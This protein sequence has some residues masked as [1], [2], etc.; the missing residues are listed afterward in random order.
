MERKSE[1]YNYVSYNTAE[2]LACSFIQY[3][4]P[5]LTIQEDQ[6]EVKHSPSFATVSNK[7]LLDEADMYHILKTAT[8]KV[9]DE[10]S[11]ETCDTT[12]NLEEQMITLLEQISKEDIA[13]HKSLYE[14]NQDDARREVQYILEKNDLELVWFD[15]RS[16]SD[17]DEY[18]LALEVL[19][20]ENVTTFLIDN[21]ITKADAAV[22]TFIKEE[23]K[24]VA[25][26]K[27]EGSA[28]VVILSGDKKNKKYAIKD[29]YIVSEHFVDVECAS[30]SSLTNIESIDSHEASHTEHS[31]EDEY[32]SDYQFTATAQ[33]LPSVEYC[34][35]NIV[36]DYEIE[37]FFLPYKIPDTKIHANKSIS[38]FGATIWT[39]E[40]NLES[41]ELF[42][43]GIGIEIQSASYNV[44]STF[45]EQFPFAYTIRDSKR[46]VNKNKSLIGATV[47]TVEETFETTNLISSEGYY[48]FSLDTGTEI[49]HNTRS[50]QNRIVEEQFC[51]PY[52]ILHSATCTSK[53]RSLFG[54][55]TETG[56]GT[57]ES[58]DLITS[59]EYCCFTTDTGTEIEGVS[60]GELGIFTEEHY[61]ILSDDAKIRT[62]I[63]E[64]CHLLRELESHLVCQLL[65]HEV[66]SLSL[67]YED[68]NA[69]SRPAYCSIPVHFVSEEVLCMEKTEEVYFMAEY[70]EGSNCCTTIDDRTVTGICT[71]YREHKPEVAHQ[72]ENSTFGRA[73]RHTVGP[74]RE[75]EMRISKSFDVEKVCADINSNSRWTDS[76]DEI[77]AKRIINFSAKDAP[78]LLFGAEQLEPQGI[79]V[80]RHP[81]TENSATQTS[82]HTNLEEKSQN[83]N[84]IG[85]SNKH[86]QTSRSVIGQRTEDCQTQT[87]EYANYRNDTLR[88]RI[89]KT[90]QDV[91]KLSQCLNPG[92][93]I[94]HIELVPSTSSRHDLLLAVTTPVPDGIPQTSKV[95]A[96]AQPLPAW[97]M[98]STHKVQGTDMSPGWQ[99]FTQVMH[100]SNWIS[101]NHSGAQRQ[102]NTGCAGYAQP[103]SGSLGI[104]ASNWLL[105][106]LENIKTHCCRAF[107]TKTETDNVCLNE[108][109]QHM[110]HL[111]K[112]TKPL[113]VAYSN[114]LLNDDLRQ[115]DQQI[116]PSISRSCHLFIATT[117][118]V[119]GEN[120]WKDENKIMSN[121]TR[122]SRSEQDFE[123]RTCVRNNL[124]LDITKTV[125]RSIFYSTHRRNKW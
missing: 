70:L 58:V 93:H 125:C 38:I 6:S 8:L 114:W 23:R 26:I 118:N 73:S 39:V 37:Q 115:K 106:T 102:P 83:T 103:K 97:R 41:T 89:R 2:F 71:E 36:E 53:S 72:V 90:E 54:A 95:T 51:I 43:V 81:V 33:T 87:N 56:K 101:P 4:V 82:Y 92:E 62:A 96:G 107:L 13:P 119:K 84:L 113:G 1:V 47:E 32:R 11:K 15:A 20:Q 77:S 17:V 117:A 123:L 57:M 55:S 122:M 69:S 10:F 85:I 60:C 124:H 50:V 65:D 78:I 49:E 120:S 67:L 61:L 22:K 18:Y 68:A 40:E 94:R 12:K 112:G 91:D 19:E 16:E 105:Q 100:T 5:E 31:S 7:E 63:G 79:Q 86:I 24:A 29:H 111:R 3:P 27:P 21:T 9:E 44:L 59:K 121:N 116:I 76:W 66:R 34:E 28:S 98:H 74:S 30:S 75:Q 109:K 25:P 35:V 108:Y 42:S 88:S 110:L 14:L 48:S 45:V 52:T 104:S 99:R 46:R 80:Q 64:R